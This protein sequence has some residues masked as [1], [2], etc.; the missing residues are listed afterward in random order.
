MVSKKFCVMCG[1]QAVK[2]SRCE[3][4]WGKEHNIVELPERLEF[5]QC[6]KCDLVLFRN[7]WVRPDFE[8]L[9]KDSAKILGE[10]DSWEIIPRD[11]KYEAFVHGWTGGVRK[12]EKH[13]VTVKLIKN[14]CQ[15]CGK[16]LG[17]YYEA[18]LQIRGDY[19]G[20]ILSWL[21]EEAER[22]GQTD[23]MAFFRYEKVKGG[24]DYFFGS[25]SAVKKLAE[26]LRKRFGAELTTSFQVAGRKQGKELRRTII[27][28]RFES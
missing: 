25:K 7:K 19:D 14:I 22:I 4:C 23:K 18:K 28:V 21:E 12:E 1:K 3:E 20:S 8:K 17:G 15:T 6:P 2:E 16:L 13:V 10:A 27:A 9:I 5:V 24:M 11:H 26:I